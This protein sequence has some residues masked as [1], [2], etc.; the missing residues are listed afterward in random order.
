MCAV[1]TS[2][3]LG[4][5]KAEMVPSPRDQLSHSSYL[6]SLLLCEVF[7]FLERIYSFVLLAR[8]EARVLFS[9]AAVT[10]WSNRAAYSI[11][12]NLRALSH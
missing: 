5:N 7:T 2:S 6:L 1:I 8:C 10:S 12:G 4:T 11:L 3:R 9:K